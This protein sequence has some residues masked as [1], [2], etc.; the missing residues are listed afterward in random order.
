MMYADEIRVITKEAIKQE[1]EKRRNQAVE[2]VNGYVEALIVANAKQG[3]NYLTI[4]TVDMPVDYHEVRTFLMERNFSV[5][6]K[7][8]YQMIDI[9][10]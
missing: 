5:D 9:R 2:W 10:W 6:Y 3:K 4:S 1:E 7:S 8:K